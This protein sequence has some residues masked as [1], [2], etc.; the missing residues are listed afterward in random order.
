MSTTLVNQ[1]K[2]ISLCYILLIVFLSENV[3]GQ[4]FQITNDPLSY[5]NGTCQT[6]AEGDYIRDH[7]RWVKARFEEYNGG[8]GLRIRFRKPNGATHSTFLCNA[9]I[10]VTR[11]G[12]RVHTVSKGTNN[13]YPSCN[14]SE[15]V[16]ELPVSATPTADNEEWRYK[17]LYNSS[18]GTSCLGGTCPTPPSCDANGYFLLQDFV[19]KK[20]PEI[21][22]SPNLTFI[23][24]SNN[25]SI[26]GTNVSVSLKVENNGAGN[27]TSNR[28][29]YYL[30]SNTT[31]TTSDYFISSS[32]LGSLSSGSTSTESINIDVANLGIPNGTYY[33]GYIIDDQG[34]VSE[35]N[36]NDNT[37]AWSGKTVTINASGGAGACDTKFEPNQN[38]AS[39]NVNAFSDNMGNSSESSGVTAYISSATD[40]DYYKLSVSHPG[41]LYLTLSTT[42]VDCDIRLYDASGN[43]LKSSTK[44]GTAME[45]IEYTH[46]GSTATYLYIK[47]FAKGSAYS[48]TQ[49]YSLGRTWLPSNNYTISGRVTDASGT[50]QGIAGVTITASRTGGSNYSATTDAS[51][52]YSISGVSSGWSGQVSAAKMG[53]YGFSPQEHSVSNTSKD[54]KD[55]VGIPHFLVISP[56]GGESFQQGQTINIEWFYKDFNGDLSLELVQGM[57]TTKYTLIANNLPHSN[58]TYS[59]KIPLD[60]PVGIYRIKLY[61]TGTFG[62][63][64][65][66]NA[67]F[68]ITDCPNPTAPENVIATD[69][70]YTNRVT[71]TWDAVAGATGYEI[72]KDG[73]LVTTT[74]LT[75]YNDYDATGIAATYTIY[76]QNACGNSS[77]SS[78]TGFK[79]VA[80]A[81]VKASDGDFCDHV[82]ISWAAV[83]AAVGYVVYRDGVQINITTSTSFKDYNASTSQAS[84]TVEAVNEVGLRIGSSDNGNVGYPPPPPTNFRASDATYA[85]KVRL[86]WDAVANAKE[87][88]ISKDGVGLVAVTGTSYD[89]LSATDQPQSYEIFAKNACGLSGVVR[90]SGYKNLAPVVSSLVVAQYKTRIMGSFEIK[91]REDNQVTGVRVF[92]RRA[93]PEP[94]SYGSHFFD[95]TEGTY[96]DFIN[97]GRLNFN[98]SAVLN[99]SLKA[100]FDRDGTYEV[101]IEAWDKR[102][103]NQSIA[104]WQ[105]NVI[106]K[107]FS[108]KK[109]PTIT[110]DEVNVPKYFIL[111]KKWK[112]TFKVTTEDQGGKWQVGTSIDETN[113]YSWGRSPVV[114][115]QAM[116][117]DFGALYDKKQ[118]VHYRVRHADYPEV[119]LDIADKTIVGNAA[120]DIWATNFEPNHVPNVLYKDGIYLKKGKLVLDGQFNHKNVT[121]KKIGMDSLVVFHDE[122]DGNQ[123]SITVENV[124]DIPISIM[125]D[126]QAFDPIN[127]YDPSITNGNKKFLKLKINNKLGRD[128]TLRYGFDTRKP[129]LSKPS[130]LQ[131]KDVEN[132]VG[133]FGISKLESANAQYTLV[134][135]A[136]LLRFNYKIG[137]SLI[138]KFATGK[139]SL[140][141]NKKRDPSIIIPNVKIRSRNVTHKFG[142]GDKAFK[143]KEITVPLYRYYFD[144]WASASLRNSKQLTNEVCKLIKSTLNKD[145]DLYIQQKRDIKIPFP[146]TTMQFGAA[147][148][149]GA[150]T[151]GSGY[152]LIKNARLKFHGSTLLLFNDGVHLEGGVKIND[153]WDYDYFNVANNGFPNN[154]IMPTTQAASV[155]ANYLNKDVGN[156]AKLEFNVDGKLNYLGD[157]EFMLGTNVLFLNSFV[158]GGHIYRIIDGEKVKIGEAGQ[159]GRLNFGFY[160]SS[161]LT[162]TFMVAA[163]GFEPYTFQIDSTN[164]GKTLKLG[165]LP[166]SA[167]TDSLCYY[168]LT[169]LDTGYVT[170]KDSVTMQISAKNLEG[171]MVLYPDSLR[172]FT[173]NQTQFKFPLVA[174]GANPVMLLAWSTVDTVRLEKVIYKYSA[175][176]IAQNTYQITL[177]YA[178]SLIGAD[179]YV[180]R[181]WEAAL[182]STSQTFRVPKSLKEIK[183]VRNGYIDMIYHNIASDTTLQV[184]A[185]PIPQITEQTSIS[186]A[187]N[188]IRFWNNITLQNQSSSGTFRLQR[189]FDESLGAGLT[190][191][192]DLVTLT[193]QGNS[194]KASLRAYVAYNLKENLT[195]STHYVVVKKNGKIE[196]ILTNENK[197]GVQFEPAPQLIKFNG[198]LAAASS[199]KFAIA[200]RLAPLITNLDSIITQQNQTLQMSI[201]E[202]FTDPDSIKNDLQIIS[203]TS[204]NPLVQLSY[205]NGQ[206]MIR[207]A[208][209]STGYS[210]LTIT[211]QHDGLTQTHTLVLA[212]VSS[213][214]VPQIEFAENKVG[215]RIAKAKTSIENARFQ[216]YLNGQ[217]VL[218]A[219][220]SVFKLSTNTASSRVQVRVI[221]A[222]G[223]SALSALITS[224]PLELVIDN[225]VKIFPNPLR[226]S[227]TLQLEILQSSWTGKMVQLHVLTPQGQ[228]VFAD[229]FRYIGQPKKMNLARLGSGAY[230]IKIVLGKRTLTIKKLIID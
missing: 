149:G 48:C 200:Q 123:I 30:S 6:V 9:E 14:V 131:A 184:P 199:V 154:L 38:L 230:F 18:G 11:G 43:L 101:K 178:D 227:K 82:A 83:P 94:T 134:A 15:F 219:T 122:E 78:D 225:L 209:C 120:I 56:N 90:N 192:S 72:R 139:F 174:S 177:Q 95:V 210:T 144:H 127:T 86:T 26:V 10:I 50:N 74:N 220:D 187:Q 223:C 161:K 189:S 148:L 163:S 58:K 63:A 205:S 8:S 176:D 2:Y 157:C 41:T 71:V 171:Y 126:N 186:L 27:A 212:N 3:L 100:L 143:G 211:A 224:I 195:D 170:E 128:F 92:V 208:D 39:A 216:W 155:Q 52:Y 162:D 104:A 54:N 7:N 60:F 21:P 40:Q 76:A 196:K 22:S 175:Q 62:I 69:G 33:V 70:K 165:M 97:E 125:I 112:G 142:F 87:Y 44:S 31:I 36:E 102:S 53:W 207:S 13:L 185:T 181:V 132:I 137:Y 121:N 80:P 118:I 140:Y 198:Q 179:I 85:H 111:G 45:N 67:T 116:T 65:Y 180:D 46:T 37:Y 89:D 99:S 29:G 59:W 68:E 12:T 160:P 42:L 84:F 110:L 93:S 191:A 81:S 98:V 124:G 34:K 158:S 61:E 24:S 214:E 221:D 183:I 133:I 119:Y 66:S 166:K 156:I 4:R 228:Q 73:V 193:N 115:G 217:A 5:L 136:D 147:S 172:T 113:D 151:N 226:G 222:N 229:S 47:V 152:I 197:H 107:Q 169:T 135:I 20:L 19:V 35:S 88:L 190:P 57:N 194:T 202:F 145:L 188:Q 108:F 17:I 201:L 164:Y 96:T 173:A 138:S 159:N 218:N 103:G 203:A 25:L 146:V 168:K 75:Y 106:T 1:R 51:G 23:S 79:F 150:S 117:Y 182:T 49:L 109:P 129:Y 64:D 28:V 215:E 114:S 130:P 91:D 213:L 206:L 204:N 32:S 105:A 16:V 141:G 77:P 167:P 153:I 55:F